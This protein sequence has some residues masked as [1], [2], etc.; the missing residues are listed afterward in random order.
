MSSGECLLISLMHFLYNSIVRRSLSAEK[1]IIV[2][3][4][5]LELALHPVAV[6]RL[7]EFLK[8]L[9]LEHDNVNVP[10]SA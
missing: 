7:I 6:V 5:E 4:D 1:K 8:E 9:V 3:I 10:K 2:L